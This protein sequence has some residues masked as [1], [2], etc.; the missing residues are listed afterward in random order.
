MAPQYRRSC[1]L[2]SPAHV[3]RFLPAGPSTT[4]P[5]SATFSSMKLTGSIFMR[6]VHHR[7]LVGAGILGRGGSP[8]RSGRWWR[9]GVVKIG[10]RSLLAHWL[11]WPSVLIMSAT[12]V[13]TKVSEETTK[14]SLVRSGAWQLHDRS[15]TRQW[16]SPCRHWPIIHGRESALYNC[17]IS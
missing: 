4:S 11:C 2:Q 14:T 17:C 5:N 7:N 6:S 9:Y 8:R 12:G 15:R 10:S 1:A 13:S 16:W 3:L